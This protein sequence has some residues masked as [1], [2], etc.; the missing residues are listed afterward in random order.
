MQDDQ[1]NQMIGDEDHPHHL[2]SQTGIGTGRTTWSGS[3][4]GRGTGRTAWSGSQTGRGTSRITWS[5][6]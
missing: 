4:T 2:G 6:S 5:G 3:Q 1:I